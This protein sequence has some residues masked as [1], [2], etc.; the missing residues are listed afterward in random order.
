VA[1]EV[2]MLNNDVLEDEDIE[3]GIVLACQSVP[4][5]DAVEISYE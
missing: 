1:G 4:V 5:T 3:E 2:K